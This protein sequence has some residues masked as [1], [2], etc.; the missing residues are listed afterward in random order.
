MQKLI[1]D[2]RNN[3]G[4]YLGAAINVANEF[5]ADDLLVYTPKIVMA[6]ATIITL[7]KRGTNRQGGGSNY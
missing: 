2:L 5:L 1:L 3:P 4:G 6:M 7:T